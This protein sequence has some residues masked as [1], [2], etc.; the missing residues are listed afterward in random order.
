MRASRRGF[1][2]IELLI[3][4]A[5][6]LILAAI[7]IPDFMKSKMAANQTSAVGTLRAIT[8]AEVMYSTNYGNGYSSTLQ[9]LAPPTGGAQPS[10]TAA[11]LVDSVVSTGVKSGYTF[12]YTPTNQDVKGGYQG[13]KV[14][15]NP[16]QV[17]ITA[18]VYY[19]V[20]QT[21]VIRQNNTQQATSTDLPLGG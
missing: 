21:N 15:A 14:N 1:S 3:V 4:V 18:N 5:I 13:Y 17:N 19:Y 9:D 6:I 16:T 11:G 2:L 7:A 12:I 10:S 20:D 8:S